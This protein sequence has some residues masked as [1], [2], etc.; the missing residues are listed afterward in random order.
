MKFPQSLT[1]LACD[2]IGPGNE[3][4]APDGVEERPAM[5]DEVRRTRGDHQ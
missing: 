5:I 2:G 4:L 1:A 3:C